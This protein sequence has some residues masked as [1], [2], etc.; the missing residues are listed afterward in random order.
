M[1]EIWGGT[2]GGLFASRDNREVT[3]FCSWRQG[4]MSL[5]HAFQL[6][7]SEEV[8]WLNPPWV[9]YL[10][11]ERVR[12]I[13]ARHD[14]RPNVRLRTLASMWEKAKCP[15][16]KAMVIGAMQRVTR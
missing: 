6:I 12:K 13:E 1:S 2:D 7:W 4:K 9:L 14:I 3:R 8:A 5:G 15:Q 16:I 11:R 10:I